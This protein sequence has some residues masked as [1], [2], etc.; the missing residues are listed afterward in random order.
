MD[1]LKAYTIFLYRNLLS[2]MKPLKI[3]EIYFVINL[4]ELQFSHFR[5]LKS[6]LQCNMVRSPNFLNGSIK[7]NEFALIH[8]S[9]LRAVKLKGTANHVKS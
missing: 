8:I 5:K 7:P 2:V 3:N 6:C 4:E 1:G 9:R